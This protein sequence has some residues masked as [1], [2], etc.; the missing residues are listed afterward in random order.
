M[1]KSAMLRVSDVCA[2]FRLLGDCRDVGSDPLRWQP[3]AFAGLCR[4]VGAHAATGGEG[5]WL[6]PTQPVRPMTQCVVGFDDR[7][8]EFFAAY[9]RAHGVLDD[10]ILRRFQHLP[11][12]ITTHSRSELVPDREWY[13][14]PSFNEYR[15]HAG[16]DHQLT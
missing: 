16:C 4:L 15:R 2:A 7:A 10:P 13:G 3:L 5:F 11:G 1:S 6:R 9:M 12:P 8:Y 14:S